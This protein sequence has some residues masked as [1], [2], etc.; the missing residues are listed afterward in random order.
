MKANIIENGTSI[1]N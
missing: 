1:A